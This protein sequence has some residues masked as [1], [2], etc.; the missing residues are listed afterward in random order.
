MVE[1]ACANNPDSIALHD[2]E[3]LEIA[4]RDIREAKGCSRWAE[5]GNDYLYKGAIVTVEAVIELAGFPR[6]RGAKIKYRDGIRTTVFTSQLEP[7]A[8]KG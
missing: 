3:R 6:P 2:A 4:A 8:K 7:L 5:F 1:A